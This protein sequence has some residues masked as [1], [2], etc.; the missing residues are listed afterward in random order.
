[1]TRFRRHLLASAT[2]HA[3]VLLLFVVFSLISQCRHRKKPH[4]IMTFIDIQSAAPTPPSI[5]EVEQVQPPAP[6]PPAPEPPKDIPEPP[7]T[8][9]KEIKK[10]EK[11]IKRTEATPPKPKLT[12]AEIRKQLS[13]GAAMSKPQGQVSDFPFAW[14]LSLVRER[15]YQAWAQPSELAGSAGLRAEV[16]IRVE[17]SG[18]ITR[19]RMVRPSGNTVM[20]QSV[21]RA[22]ESVSTLKELPPGYGGAYKDITIEFELTS[23]F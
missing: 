14:Y 7:K 13:E 11:K 15:M 18:T 20:D 5:A 12:E 17:R 22:V 23:P 16:E 21:M 9:K 1:M 10:S 8:P 6:E 4:E 2:A 19:R 3:A